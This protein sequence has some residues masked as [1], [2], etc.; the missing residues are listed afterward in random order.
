MGR[1][2][3]FYEKNALYIWDQD[4]IISVDLIG[5]RVGRQLVRLNELSS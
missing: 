1:D 2:F 4:I 5:R 3:F